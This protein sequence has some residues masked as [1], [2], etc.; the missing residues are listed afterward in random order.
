V[1]AVLDNELI[2]AHSDSN[3][4]AEVAAAEALCD[5]TGGEACL[6]VLWGATSSQSSPSSSGS[7][8]D[9][10]VAYLC[11]GGDSSQPG[12]DCKGPLS[13]AV[14]ESHSSVSKQRDSGAMAAD[15]ESDGADVCLGGEASDGTCSGLGLVVLHA[16]GHSETDGDDPGTSSGSSYAAGIELGG[17]STQVGSDP[18]VFPPGCPDDGSAVCVVLNDNDTGVTGQGSGGAVET[19]GVVILPGAVGADPL[20]DAGVVSGSSGVSPDE[21]DTGGGGGGGGGSGGGGIGGGGGGGAGGGGGGA[22]AADGSAAAGAG[23]GGNGGLARTGAWFLML[24]VLMLAL[25]VAGAALLV[26][27]RRRRTPA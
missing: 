18:V 14:A 15:H 4:S 23:D 8:S 20:V 6:A 25:T 22:G 2:A 12:A 17:E 7:S 11:L 13:V 10:G 1:L 16:E 5:E 27:G 3:G 21:G 9:T 26:Q 19:V 24:G